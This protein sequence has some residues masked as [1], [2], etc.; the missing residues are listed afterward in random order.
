MERNVYKTKWPLVP[1]N[2]AMYA[3][4]YE[5]Q[6]EWQRNFIVNTLYYNNFFKKLSRLVN[7]HIMT[8]IAGDHPTP[9][10][11]YFFDQFYHVFYN[12][13]SNS[14]FKHSNAAVRYIIILTSTKIT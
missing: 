14:T 5:R 10:P 6:T 2:L 7:E 4:S 13:P 12:P 8:K 3:F 1:M 11:Y 9:S